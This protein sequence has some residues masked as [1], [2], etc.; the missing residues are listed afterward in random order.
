MSTNLAQQDANLTILN[1]SS[2]PTL[3]PG[4]ARRMAPFFEKPRLI[5]DR[6]PVRVPRVRDHLHGSTLPEKDR[7]STMITDDLQL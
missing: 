1:A 3:L 5:D 7:D 2:R 6:D 4:H